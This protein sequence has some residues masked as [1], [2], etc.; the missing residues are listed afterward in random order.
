[1]RWRALRLTDV[2]C[3]PR[4][5]LTKARRAGHWESRVKVLPGCAD[6]WGGGTAPKTMDIPSRSRRRPGFDRAR[7]R[8]R[9]GNRAQTPGERAQL[10][11]E[12]L[13]GLGVGVAMINARTGVIEHANAA[14]CGLIGGTVSDVVGCPRHQWILAPEETKRRC[15]DEEQAVQNADAV[16][17]RRDGSALSVL[18]SVKCIELGGEEKLVETF[19]DISDR[20]VAE[21]ALRESEEKHRLLVENSHDVIYTMTL[22]GV[23]T[24]VSPAWTVV[25]GHPVSDVLGRSIED[26]IHPDDLLRCVELMQSAITQG[27]RRGGVEY[28]IRDV[29]GCWQWHTSSGLPLYDKAGNIIGFEG[30]ARDIT[31]R[32]NAEEANERFRVGFDDGAVPQ[33]LIAA[34]GRFLR[35][36]DALATLLG[37]AKSELLA[38]SFNDITHP[39]DRP[40]GVHGLST[41]LSS[42]SKLRLEKRYVT[43]C[44]APVWVD[45]NVAA[46]RDLGGTVQYFIGTYVDITERKRI[47]EALRESESNFRAF[48][49]SMTDMVIVGTPTGQIL[50]TNAAFTRTLGYSAEE[51]LRLNVL[52]LHPEN[53]RPDIA[54]AFSAVLRKEQD[55]SRLPLV[56]KSGAI[57]PAES[58]VWIGRWNGA[59]CVFG[60]CRNITAEREAH[61]LFEQVFRNNPAMMALMELPSRRLIDVNE[62]YAMVLGYSRDEIV[63]RRASEIGLLID[64]E[65]AFAM[66]DSLPSTG[67]SAE[68]EFGMRRKD[69][70][71]IE[72]LCSAV[73]IRIEGRPHCLLVHTEITQRKRAED[74]LTALSERLWLAVQAGRVGIFDYDVAADRLTWDEV[75]FQLYGV[76]PD[77][78]GGVHDVWHKSLHPE[79]VARAEAEFG[80]ALR[81]E[82][83]FNTEF[84]VVWPDGSNHDIR[85]IARVQWDST[86][87]PVRMIGT[88]WDITE[89]KR[90]QTN[91]REA[92]RKLEETTAHAHAMAEKAEKASAAK[93]EFLANMSHEIRTPMNGVIGMTGLLL[94][95]KLTTEQ[96]R[97][98]ELVRGSA[99][100]LLTVIN[101]ILDFSKIEAGKLGLEVLDFNL[102]LLLDELFEL[103]MPQAESKQLALACCMSPGV[104]ACL[105]GDPGRVRQ[106]LVNLTNN[107]LKF[108]RD[109]EVAVWVTLEKETARTA[110]LRFAVRDT[111]IGIAPDDQGTVFEKFTQVDAS[112]TRRYGGTGLGLAICKQLANLMGGEIGV[113]SQV[114]CGS[115]FWFTALFE[116][117]QPGAVSLPAGVDGCS[118]S[119]KPLADRRPLRNLGR[120]GVRVLLAEDNATNQQVALA[121]L[122]KLGLSADAVNNG[123]EAL[124]ALRR[125]P[126]DL[127]LMDV[128]M[129]ELDGYGASRAIR[130]AEGE[131]LN[132]AIPII[133]MTAHAM[134]GDRE[135][136]LAAG[137]DDYIAKPVSPSALALV[138]E[139]WLDKIDVA[140][141]MSA[142]PKTPSVAIQ[143]D[144]PQASVE[145]PVFGEAA[146]VD[147][148]MGDRSLAAVVVSGFLGDI[149]KQID[150]LKGSAAVGD[151][152]AVERQAHTIKGAAA[153]VSADVLAAAAL[154]VEQ[155]GRAGDLETAGHGIAEIESQFQRVRSAMKSSALLGG[156]T[157]ERP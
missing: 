134:Q 16:L 30:I 11:R 89:Q 98:A 155:A 106:V 69:G 10:P 104:P 126:Y 76:P 43:R 73:A 153:T 148:L 1:L 46:V 149:P 141:R 114:G 133:A 78:F 57:I 105:R 150:A 24:Y 139:T 156:K 140:K 116:K 60:V 151:L 27:L 72:V 41:M 95:T 55:C 2:E 62:T 111:G 136:C 85:A 7:P 103:M 132:R 84:R 36:N 125:I 20:K 9:A 29:S 83:D 4:P 19:V 130:A 59:Q 138:L 144:N 120:P 51:A 110:T 66:I 146:L 52:E 33:A 68:H 75:M 8:R 48:F 80:L 86:G 96:R 101:D 63:G 34:D 81:G 47:E 121:I 31:D 97:Y 117:G 102:Q 21:V 79:D 37:Y 143:V 107:A 118:P 142:T 108:T 14:L 115:E 131:T 42:E 45:V 23:F 152:R 26:F 154:S 15:D 109:G 137:M 129:P 82:R 17:L 113:E 135:A 39:D 90:A 74:Q 88:N 3:G 123:R 71:R 147:R 64:I 54:E 40:A 145:R 87:R 49:N 94:G 122:Q 12:V 13:D 124:E 100:S 35:V 61:Q 53:M 157:E 28:R 58:R 5:R 18:R 128:Q 22:T 91:L 44:G 38:K 67:C 92:N 56:A 32:K 25:L 50:Y 99:E 127:V 93:S 6:S 65:P 77:Q 119:Q 70:T 112:T